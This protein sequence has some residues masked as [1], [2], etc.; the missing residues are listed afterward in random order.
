MNADRSNR[1]LHVFLA[2]ASWLALGIALA[3]AA[4]ALFSHWAVNGLGTTDLGLAL[5]FAM[6]GA[7]SAIATL[8]AAPVLTLAG[9]ATVFFERRSG[10]RFL[11]AGAVCGLPLAVLTLLER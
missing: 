11:A 3:A 2:L 6:L 9:V 8:Y 4:T 1:R 5:F 10:L 7:A